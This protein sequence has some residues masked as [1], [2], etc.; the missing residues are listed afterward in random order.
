MT[1]IWPIPAAR[2][3]LGVK[4]ERRSSMPIGAVYV[5]ENQARVY[6][7]LIDTYIGACASVAIVES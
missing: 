2:R 7:K 5:A 4:N 1:P 6:L 3:P